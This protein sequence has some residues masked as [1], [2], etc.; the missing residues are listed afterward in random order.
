MLSKAFSFLNGLGYF[1]N[2][3]QITPD[4]LNQINRK[5]ENTNLRR[6]VS[7]QDVVIK[8]S[9]INE[10]FP[11]DYAATGQ[12]IEEL[13]RQLERRGMTIEVFTGQPGYAFSISV[14]ASLETQ[15]N[16]RIQRSRSTK[17]WSK[18]IRGRMIRGLLF[19]ARA[20]LH[21][22]KHSFRYDLFL[23]TS[24]PPFLA[25]AGYLAHI[26][27]FGKISYIC[28][29]YDLYPDIAIRLDVIDAKHWVIKLWRGINREIWKKA[30]AIIV[31]SEGMKTEV[32]Q[33]A[34]EILPKV[35]V[36]PSWSDPENIIPLPKIDNWFAQKY[37]LTDCFTV[38]YSG[39]MGRCHDMNTILESMKQLKDEAVQFVFIGGGPK[40][41]DFQ[42]RVNELGLDKTIFLSYQDKNILPYS[43]TACD[44]A[45]VSVAPEVENLVAPSKIYSALAAGK[46]IA[47]ICPPNSYLNKL[48]T[49]SQCGITVKNGD[50]NSL[51]DFICKLK[52]NPE[53]ANE[54]GRA[55]RRYLELN[56]TPEIIT[57]EYIKVFKQAMTL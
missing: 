3:T 39:N 10:F 12:L 8:L 55:S 44:L 15:G 35:A 20:F 23:L 13:A 28:L 47:V 5:E 16:V 36:I 7:N 29:I 38:L 4:S 24:A 34:P 53:L 14:A 1:F 11:P 42:R 30:K 32:G 46:A 6:N 49:D 52:N 37:Q 43:L 45:L 22:I 57:T 51:T 48:V 21:I 50:Q 26:L 56:F 25:I 41:E 54:I 31:L 2:A 17:L 9:I 40:L 18:R 27:S 19:T 33:L